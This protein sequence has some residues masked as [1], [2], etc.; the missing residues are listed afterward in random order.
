[1][2]ATFSN[3]SIARPIR[4]VRLQINGRRRK[5]PIKDV[6]FLTVCIEATWIGLTEKTRTV[7]SHRIDSEFR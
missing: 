5:R 7:S 4:K 6:F 1:M 2:D 3:E